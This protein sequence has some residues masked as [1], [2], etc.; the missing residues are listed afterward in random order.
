MTVIF[1]NPIINNYR[2]IIHNIKTCTE[3][4]PRPV[5]I[6]CKRA[7]YT[8]DLKVIFTSKTSYATLVSKKIRSKVREQVFNVLWGKIGNFPK[9]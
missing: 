8:D 7:C 3:N 1:L 9:T 5:N 2:Y 4:E 6:V